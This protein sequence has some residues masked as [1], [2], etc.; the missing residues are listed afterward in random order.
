MAEYTSEK[1]I[2][3]LT[4]PWSDLAMLRDRADAVL[5]ANMTDAVQRTLR[6]ASLDSADVVA[7][8]L[9]YARGKVAGDLKWVAKLIQDSVGAV[10][11]AERA[12][13]N[14]RGTSGSVNFGGQ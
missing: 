13:N 6:S 4:E 8:Q 10:C 3:E 9:R 2:R 1:A 12:V 14:N 7:D 5:S 11:T